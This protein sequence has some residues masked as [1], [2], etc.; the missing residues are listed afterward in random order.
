MYLKAL[1]GLFAPIARVKKYRTNVHYITDTEGH[2]P[3]FSSSIKKSTVVRFDS[4][5]KLDFHPGVRDPYFI[6]GGDLTDRG[7][8]DLKLARMLLDFKYRYSDRVILLVG[9]RES[10]KTRFF[11]ELNPKYIRERLI[12]GSAPFWLLSA[13]HQLP[14]DYVKKHM[15]ANHKSTDTLEDIEH[16]VNCLDIEECQLIYLK[17]MLEQNLGCPNTFYYHQQ[18][19]ATEKGCS[20]TDISDYMVLRSILEQNS[21]KGLIGEY[22]QQTQL[23]AIIPQAGIFAVHGG[24]TEE[25]IGRLPSMQPSDPIIEDMHSW[26]DQFN[27]WY[28][29]EVTRWADLNVEN[30]LL[31]LRPARSPLDTFSIRVPSEYRSIVAA[32]MLDS[33]RRFVPVPGLVSDYLYRNGIQLVLSGHQPCGDHPALLRSEDDRVVFINGDTSYANSRA[34]NIHDTRGPSFHTLQIHANEDHLNINIDAS[35]LTGKEIKNSLDMS[36]GVVVDET[37]IGK[38]LPG[39]ELVQCLLDGGYYRTI[40]QEGFKVEYK[41]RTKEEIELLLSKNLNSPCSHV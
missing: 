37:P 30:M 5:G 11:V 31:D 14:I 34:N 40:I 3:S 25:N 18:H 17:W 33:Q 6:F 7:V 20:I 32:S 21:P 41:F 9:N 29:T 19:L 24:L 36:N 23:A 12:K 15:E 13:P 39:N 8:G 10:S 26:I 28:K 2:Y 22:I 4:T 16:Y 38:L 1:N 27:I 35:L